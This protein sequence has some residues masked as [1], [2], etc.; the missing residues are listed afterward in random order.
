MGFGRKV[1]TLTVLLLFLIS[2]ILPLSVSAAEPLDFNREIQFTIR[3]EYGET[4]VAG[5]QFYVYK[6]GTIG[7]DAT[8]SLSAPFSSYPISGASVTQDAAELLYT[9]AL[10]DGLS[11]NCILT[12]DENGLATETL[13]AGLYLIVP[14]RLSNSYGIFRSSPMLVT[15]PHR[16]SGQDPWVY[17]V[18][19]EP[20]CSFTPRNRI[21][22]M[23]LSVMKLWDIPEDSDHPESVT[24]HL[25]KDSTLADTVTLSS[26]N[27]WVH[28]WVELSEEYDWR[29][30]EAPIDG[31]TVSIERDAHIIVI[32]N[33][34]EEP[35]EPDIPITPDETTEPTTSPT[36][37]D[38]PGESTTESSTEPSTEPTADTT[39]STTPSKPTTPTLPQTGMLWWPVPILAFAGLLLIVMGIMLRRGDTDEA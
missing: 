22:F 34:P 1:C 8:V 25:F 37:P 5:A 39:Q 29:V 7:S 19:V 2:M 4:P 31:Y 36:L 11:A 14:Q 32:T 18:T 20:K 38:T 28:K 24:I 15:L 26:S 13:S 9:Y 21:G 12:T 3:Y 27:R 16:A 23:N 30:V 6:A 17:D 35:S 33:T 10:L